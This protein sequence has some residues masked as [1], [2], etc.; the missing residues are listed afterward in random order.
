MSNVRAGVLAV[1]AV[2]QYR[3]RDILAY[4]GLRYYLANRCA[5]RDRW[6]REIARHLVLTRSHPAYFHALHYKEHRDRSSVEH[7]DI[8]LPGPN[9]ALA[10]AALLDECSRHPE[11]FGTS[12]CT[13]SYRLAPDGHKG[14]IFKAYFPGFRE[15]HRVVA[16]ACRKD[17]ASTVLYTDIKRFYP[18]VSS[19]LAEQAWRQACD[20]AKLETGFRKL[21]ERILQDHAAVARNPQPQATPHGGPSKTL[22]LLTGPMLSHLIGNLVLKGIDARMSESLPGGYF[23]YVD[24]FIL[25]GSESRVN[26]AQTQLAKLLGDLGLHLHMHASPK[27]FRVAASEWLEGADDF[28]DDGRRPSWRSFVG[29]LK[30][31]LL[32]KPEKRDELQKAF[33]TEGMRI[34]VPDY[35]EAVREAASLGS[36]LDLAREAWFRFRVKQ[37]TVKSLVLDAQE[38]RDDFAERLKVQLEGAVR[39]QGFP[40]KRRIPKLRFFAGRLIY[41]GTPESLSGFI[42]PLGS[43]PEVRLLSEVLKAIV[44]RDVTDLLP[45]GVNAVQ[46]AAQVLRLTSQTV[47]CRCIA[48]QRA[49]SQGLAILRLNGLALDTATAMNLPEDDLNRFAQW[50]GIGIDLMR[51]EDR[52][53]REVACLHGVDRGRRHETLLD[54]AFDRDEQ[55]AF[56]A[57]SQLQPS[58]Y[59]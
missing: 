35:S 15:R 32:A 44:S 14:G 46:A 28:E 59:F 20:A 34:P 55:L 49:E 8:H 33:A 50:T 38:L 39:L 13:F 37:L 45:L 12:P 4:L 18:S 53:L 56:D 40:R 22:G 58:S 7:R 47:S 48:W 25:V 31:F 3:R 52:A 27:G 19:V 23:R 9:E 36:I 42:N 6:A 43:I 21:G 2:N 10:E 51:S 30:H 29:G 24:D 1:R 26:A 57:I 5:V 11:A 16:E 54:S 17:G 41:L